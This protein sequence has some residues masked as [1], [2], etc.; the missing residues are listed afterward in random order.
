MPRV[1][2]EGCDSNEVQTYFLFTSGRLSKKIAH[3]QSRL[4]ILLEI[5][6]EGVTA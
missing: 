2:R 3:P 5:G 4:I 1:P 6:G